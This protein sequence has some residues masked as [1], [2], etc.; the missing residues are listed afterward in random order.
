MTRRPRW[1]ET[2]IVMAGLAVGLT[3]CASSATS[4]R[5]TESLLAQAGF[6]QMPADTPQKVAHMQTLPDRRLIARTYKDTKYYVY[7]DPEGCKC[8]YIGRQEQYDAYKNLGRQQQQA[9]PDYVE[10]ARQWEE[11]NAG[12]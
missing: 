12:R 2:A 11:Q 8:V 4:A 7:S 6:R 10:E 5:T 9:T 1:T 3:A